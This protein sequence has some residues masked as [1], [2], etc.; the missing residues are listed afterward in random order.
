MNTSL[1]Q[2]IASQ[3]QIELMDFQRLHGGDIN[4][5]YLLKSSEN[6]VVKIND[7]NRFPGMFDAEAK[8]LKLLVS[9]DSFR[10]PKVINQGDIESQSYLLLEYIVE[11]TPKTDFAQQFAENL[12]KLHKTTQETFGL[13]HDNYIGSLPQK[14]LSSDSAAEFYI[15]QRLEPQ[16]KMAFDNG[17]KFKDVEIVFKNISDEVPEEP[18]A[19]IHGDLWAGNYLVDSSGSPVLIDPAV[20]FASREMDLAMMKLFGGFDAEIFRIYEELF[21][22]EPEWQKRIKMWQLYYLLVHLNLF[23][24]SYYSGVKNIIKSYS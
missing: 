4:D 16:I 7:A 10:I 13:D 21:P 3:N 17:F 14:N 20:S 2:K 24:N 5:V 8:G 19:L 9:S 12:V 18:P 22:P 11:G 15:S 23:G 1:L 6:F